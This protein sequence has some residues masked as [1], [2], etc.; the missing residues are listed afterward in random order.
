MGK[1]TRRSSTQQQKKKK[2]G[3]FLKLERI[4]QRINQTYCVSD[5]AY[6]EFSGSFQRHFTK[7]LFWLKNLP[8]HPQ[9]EKGPGGQSDS[10]LPGRLG[11]FFHLVAH[12]MLRY[13]HYSSHS[14]FLTWDPRLLWEQN[15]IFIIINLISNRKIHSLTNLATNHSHIDSIR[16]SNG[17]KNHIYFHIIVVACTRK[18]HTY[19]YFEVL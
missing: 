19:Q 16:D 4:Q 1:L 13:Q 8:C 10:M 12:S 5:S 7:L 17:N 6:N 11:L 18:C 15:F 2:G 9:A 14:G 3:Q